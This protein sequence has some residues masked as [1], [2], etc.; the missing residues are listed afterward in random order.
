MKPGNTAIAAARTSK[1]KKGKTSL[2]ANSDRICYVNDWYDV[3]F[4]PRKTKHH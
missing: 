2:V 4:D 3:R 1:I